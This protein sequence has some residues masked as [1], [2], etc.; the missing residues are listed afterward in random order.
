ME[1]QLG[2]EVAEVVIHHGN[3]VGGREP[4]QR[5]RIIEFGDAAIAAPADHAR[6]RDIAAAAMQGQG[7]DAAVA[8]DDDQFIEG[9]DGHVGARL[10]KQGCLH[11]AHRRHITLGKCGKHA[12]GLSVEIGNIEQAFAGL[13]TGVGG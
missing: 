13:V 2:G 4:G 3:F 8:G 5:G 12:N 7:E 9:R 6:R 11:D 1:D 10:A